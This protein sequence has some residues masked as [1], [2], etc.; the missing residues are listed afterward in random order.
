[1]VGKRGISIQWV[2]R[3]YFRRS[4]DKGVGYDSFSSTPTNWR[5]FCYFGCSFLRMRRTSMNVNDVVTEIK[6]PKITSTMK[7]IYA[8]RF[9]SKI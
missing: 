5:R 7:S 3:K 2:K 4:E 8:V 9:S 1:M 6:Q